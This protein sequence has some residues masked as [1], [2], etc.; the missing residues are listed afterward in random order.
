[1]KKQH[2]IV[3]GATYQPFQ[4]TAELEESL[5]VIEPPKNFVD[6]EK[7]ANH[8]R[9]KTEKRNEELAEVWPLKKFASLRVCYYEPG[10]EPLVVAVDDVD[11]ATDFVTLLAPICDALERIDDFKENVLFVGVGVRDILR[12]LRSRHGVDGLIPYQKIADQRDVI[13]PIGMLNTGEVAKNLDVLYV[14]RDFGIEMPG[15]YVPGKSSV[16][17][18]NVAIRSYNTLCRGRSQPKLAL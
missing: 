5:P 6:P 3:L 16:E 7:K 12:L 17:D 4:P 2:V 10:K 8:V 15:D 1:M 11:P 9:G 14:L 13:D 18:C